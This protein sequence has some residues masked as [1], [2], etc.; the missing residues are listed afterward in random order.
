MSQIFGPVPSRR[1]GFSLGVDTIPYKT[2]TLDC[3]YCQ[4]GRTTNKT[5]ERKEYILADVIVDEVEKIIKEKKKK[6][7]YITFSGSGEP[8]LNLKI[9]DM[10]ER[11][12]KITTIPIA[13]LTNGTLLYSEKLRDELKKADLVIPSLDAADDPTFR[14]VSR[15]HPSLSFEMMVS[16]IVKFSQEFKGKIWLEIMLV[17]GINDSLKHIQKISK[18][19]KEI[20][21]DK[22]QLNTPVRPPAEEFVRPLS[23]QNLEK[24]KS[25]LGDKCEVI[26]AFKRARQ[27]AYR[28]DVEEQIITLIKRRPVTL[29]DISNSLGIH[30]NEV[31]KYIESLSDKKLLQSKIYSGKRYY[32]PI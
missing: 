19:I 2:C 28:E 21:V 6:I 30:R 26:A 8:T 7:D 16:G 9:G 12:K 20:R 25:L 15:P 23:I 13:V 32:Y 10:I 29:T 24:I 22:I 4:L 5:L 14:Q 1:L 27:K 11:I 3:I 18:I 31:I 17:K